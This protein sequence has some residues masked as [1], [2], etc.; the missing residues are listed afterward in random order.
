M[1]Q[2]RRT[3]LK[4]ASLLAALPLVSPVIEALGAGNGKKNPKI[5]L[6]SSWQTVN[7]GDIGHTF[8]IMVLFQRYLPEAQITLWPN[9]IE[10]GVDTLLTTNFPSMKIAEGKI[11][12]DGKP[13]TPA[14]QEAFAT[15][16]LMVHGSAPWIVVPKDL[17]AWHQLTGKPFGFYGISLDEL[18]PPLQE[19]V[20]K[21]S[22]LYCRDSASLHYL[23]SLA[24]KCPVQALGLDATFAIGL[25]NEQKANSY[26]ASVGLKRGEFIC[27]IPRLRYTPYW[28]MYNRAPT[29]EDT[30]RYTISEAYKEVDAAKLREVMTRWIQE[31]GLKVLACPEV[32]YQVDLAKEV[33]VD[34]LP[35]EIKKNVVWRSTYWH[36]DEAGSIYAQANALVSFEMHSPIIAFT[37]GVPSIHLKQP[38]DTRKGQMWADI[39][40]GDWLFEIDETPGSQIANTLLR[41]HHNEAD[42]RKKMEQAR[43]MVQS[44]QKET[45]THIKKF[46]ASAK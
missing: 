10:N 16:D 5:L 2:H 44:T 40:L 31:T 34:P 15:C 23:Q 33:L 11:G 4:Q 38:S 12:T 26:L 9:S 24:L 36:P 35:P 17:E 6:R 1:Q 27:V 18:T 3:F 21:A 19:L 7:I 25:K 20:N 41:L 42:T 13:N 22:F 8:G 30:R 39:G 46:I 29:A 45:M 43:A 28:K 37:E 32:T 14:L